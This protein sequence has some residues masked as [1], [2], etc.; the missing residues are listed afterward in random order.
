MSVTERTTSR[1]TPVTARSFFAGF[2]PT[3]S[4]NA[5]RHQHLHAHPEGVQVA[6]FYKKVHD[7]ILRPLVAA[8]NQ[9]RAPIELRPALTTIDKVIANRSTM[10]LT[11]A[12]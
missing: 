4:S 1:S 3:G 10:R 2:V 5:S 11:P 7:R 6:V 12:A 9:P 8:G